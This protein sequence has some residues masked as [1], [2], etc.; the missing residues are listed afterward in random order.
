MRRRV[1]HARVLL[2]GARRIARRKNLRRVCVALISMRMS[3][4]IATTLIV[5]IRGGLVSHQNAVKGLALAMSARV[6]FLKARHYAILAGLLRVT[7]A[8]AAMKEKLE[9]KEYSYTSVD[10]VSL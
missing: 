10:P 3:V 5:L 7:F 6:G 1:H 4:L 2:F 9:P 8:S